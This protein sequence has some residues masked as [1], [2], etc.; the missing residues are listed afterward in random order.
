MTTGKIIDILLVVTGIG[1]CFLGV[2]WI[3]VDYASGS[4]DGLAASALGL[5]IMFI[6]VV[7]LISVGVFL[8]VKGQREAARLVEVEKERKLLGVV[9]AQG[10]A[11]IS[12]MAL[13]LDASRNQV[14]AWLYDLV[15]MDYLL[16][17]SIGIK[18]RC[19]SVMQPN[20]ATVNAPIAVARWN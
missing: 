3:G 11:Q 7:P 20:C 14:K 2:M 8:F 5:G 9:Q 12:D 16:V 18:L 19:I 13:E 1:F 6:L 10:Q 15:T 17:I 4:Y